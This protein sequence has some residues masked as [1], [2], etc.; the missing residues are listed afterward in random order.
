RATPGRPSI[1]SLIPS[2]TGARTWRARLACRERTRRSRLPAVRTSAQTPRALP[3]SRERDHEA[4][5]ALEHH[6]ALHPGGHSAGVVDED[7][8]VEIPHLLDVS[9]LECRDSCEQGVPPGVGVG[10]IRGR[11]YAG[12]RLVTDR[13]LTAAEVAELSP[14]ARVDA[15]RILNAAARRLLAARLDP[16][17]LGHLAG[18]DI[19]AVEHGSDECPPLVE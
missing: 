5:V 4:L 12:A 13:L 6:H 8:V 9:T 19:D 2:R 11:V 1:S 16:D 3:G 18:L 15:T 10:A 14:A 7:L 17:S